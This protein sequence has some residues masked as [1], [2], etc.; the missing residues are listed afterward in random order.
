[1]VS[2]IDVNMTEAISS[3]TMQTSFGVVLRMLTKPYLKTPD[4]VIIK[5]SLLGL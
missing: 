5:Q 4:E 2:L 3:A 1:M